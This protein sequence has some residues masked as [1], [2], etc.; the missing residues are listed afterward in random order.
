MH[1]AADRRH[2][3]NPGVQGIVDARLDF[4]LQTAFTTK[5]QGWLVS[6]LER[7]RY[8]PWTEN[9]KVPRASSPKRA[10]KPRKYLTEEEVERLMRAARETG[11]DGEARYNAHPARLSA[12]RLFEARGTAD[13]IAVGVV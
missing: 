7:G 11:R 5:G 1:A 3:P 9:R 13:G 6:G 12:A 8:G 4:E 10:A 2:N